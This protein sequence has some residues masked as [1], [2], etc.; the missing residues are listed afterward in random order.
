MGVI[1]V[2]YLHDDQMKK[3]IL[4]EAKIIAIVGISDNPQRDSFR[5][6][7]YLQE[8]GYRIIPV[9]PFIPEVLGEVAFPDL[10]SIPFPV[11]IV[12]V[13]R[14]ESELPA[15][16]NQALE[17]GS[18]IIWLQEGLSYPQG[19]ALAKAGNAILIEDYCLKVEHARLIGK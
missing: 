2:E 18:R 7:K 10:Q 6:A 3:K 16:I 11:D 4:Q 15:V 17:I 5:V 1:G 8:K 19:R 13:F 12:D 14:R 9:N